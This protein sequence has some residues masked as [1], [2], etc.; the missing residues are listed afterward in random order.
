MHT[1]RKKTKE[2]VS[3]PIITLASI[4]KLVSISKR[5]G[6]SIF[7]NPNIPVE[8]R[9]PVSNAK[10]SYNSTRDSW[11]ANLNKQS[12]LILLPLAW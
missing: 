5:V 10:H 11:L 9:R 12:L 2:M 6:Y 7:S 3:V 4:S 8:E 1:A